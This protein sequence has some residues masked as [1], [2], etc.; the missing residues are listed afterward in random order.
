MRAMEVWYDRVDVNQVIAE[1]PAVA[2]KRLRARVKKTRGQSSVDHDFPKLVESTSARPRRTPVTRFCL[3]TDMPKV[4]HYWNIQLKD[5]V[6]N[7]VEYVYRLSSLNAATARISSDGKLRAARASIAPTLNIL[8]TAPTNK[9]GPP[10]FNCCASPG[11]VELNGQDGLGL[12]WEVTV[13]RGRRMRAAR[14]QELVV[15]YPKI[16]M[17]SCA[18]GRWRRPGC[19]LFETTAKIQ[20]VSGPVAKRTCAPQS[21]PATN[22]GG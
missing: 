15:P 21:A 16:M 11:V 6:F 7:A 4:R 5:P 19:C 14:Y 8:P 17:A 20:A 18:F 3:E 2:Q 22:S 12:K 10:A 9:T 13:R 1:L